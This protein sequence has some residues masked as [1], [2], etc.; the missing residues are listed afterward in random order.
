MKTAVV[1]GPSVVEIRETKRPELGPDDIMVKM[2]AC[3][4]CGSDVE[5]VFGRY[6]QPSMR[7]GHEPVGII[8]GV[9]DSV[10][11]FSVGDRVFAHHHV[12]CYSCH[13]CNH[14]RETMCPR[15]YEAN[16]NP[17]GLS[18]EFVV[19]GWNVKRGGVLKLP[20]SLTF[21]AAT[22]I[23]PLACCIRSWKKIPHQK[24]DSVAVYGAGPTGMMHAML[25]KAYGFEE[26]FCLDVN[27][28]RVDFAKRL[29]VTAAIRADDP[30]RR[31]TVISSTGGGV[32]AAVVATSSIAALQDAVGVTR[33]GGTV[34]MFGVPSASSRI[35]LDLADVY[36]REITISTSYAAADD[37][38]R[39][40]LEMIADSRIP[41][42]TLITHRYQLQDSQSAFDHART[43]DGAMKIIITDSAAIPD[44]AIT[45][46]Q[47]TKT[48]SASHPAQ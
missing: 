21:E 22:M 19:P 44:G 40:A 1:A 13:Y 16:L 32:D 29:E 27:P 46:E 42:H 4:I 20:D 43:G 34:M 18:E 9:G 47:K 33:R 35:N 15:Y 3:G 8:T 39:M 30:R 37:D 5:K 25:A 6:G 12:P 24:G 14:G 48:G 11:E 26:I 45:Q 31:E 17:C 2:H 36:S 7:L 38:T 23:E 41:V 10:L 28:F